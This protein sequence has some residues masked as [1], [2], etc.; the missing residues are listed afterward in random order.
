MQSSRYSLSLRFSASE[1]LKLRWHEVPRTAS[2]IVR[3]HMFPGNCPSDS[4]S[5]RFRFCPH[6]DAWRLSIHTEPRP[7]GRGQIHIECAYE[8]TGAAY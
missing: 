4:V 7:S 6:A 2:E 5:G 3:D 1:L 8:M